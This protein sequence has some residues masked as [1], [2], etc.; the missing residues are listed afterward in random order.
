MSSFNRSYSSEC[1]EKSIAVTAGNCNRGDSSVD[2]AGNNGSTVT[3]VDVDD[4]NVGST[5][6]EHSEQSRHSAKAGSVSD[7]CGN[8]D[9]R[10]SH[11]SGNHTREC[12]FHSG[13]DND[14][15][16][17]RQ[18]FPAIQQTVQTGNADVIECIDF[19]PHHLKGNNRFLSNRHVRSTGRHDHHGSF[20]DNA[21][22]LAHRN[23]PG[24]FV[25]FGLRYELFNPVE[26]FGGYS[27][28]EDVVFMLV[29]R[30]DD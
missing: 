6:I 28:D 26:M 7:A 15:T 27:S 1:N 12:P 10:G 23:R 16:G 21:I 22:V 29:H 5:A 4:R 30:L 19:V 14:H 25:K 8:S 3:I 18:T 24:T 17:F 9:N 2:Q 11:Q 20:T 13:H